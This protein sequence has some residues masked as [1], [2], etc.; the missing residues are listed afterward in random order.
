MILRNSKKLIYAILVL[1]LVSLSCGPPRYNSQG[2][3]FEDGEAETYS[4]IV[5]T[6]E[7]LGEVEDISSAVE[8]QEKCNPG[9]LSYAG[10]KETLSIEQNALIVVDENGQRKYT[11]QNFGQFCRELDN[12]RLECIEQLTLNGTSSDGYVLNVYENK[13]NLELCFRGYL[14]H[15]FVAPPTTV[16]NQPAV[17][18]NN[19]QENAAEAQG[20]PEFQP[21]SCWVK[22]ADYT[23]EIVN[24]SDGTTEQGKRSCNADGKITNHSEQ[25]LVYAI[26]RVNH[27]GS[28]EFFGEKWLFGYQVLLP[29]ET[30]EYGG[31][32]HCVGGNCGEGEWFYIQRLSI[33]YNIPE[34][35]RYS[36]GLAD[37]AP[38]SIINIENPCD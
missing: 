13:S 12:G 3:D 5:G 32:H 19:L 15:N 38:E 17:S 23:L 37:M 33:L 34:C 8:V 24:F 31:F 29:G 4:N 36:T 1:I 7:S 20:S 2:V 6:Y 28:E 21:A 30:V 18:E 9:V 22:P 11:N 25:E 16:E 14:S 10:K 35:V 27:Y 26:Y